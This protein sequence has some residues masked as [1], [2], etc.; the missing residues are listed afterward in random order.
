MSFVLYVS[1]FAYVRYIDDNI[2]Q[3]VPLDYIKGFSPQDVNDFEI[4]KKYDVLW[5]K[6]P[7]DQGQYYKAQILKLAGRLLKLHCIS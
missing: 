2:R 3:I 7:E 1:M 5:K 4:R 6:S